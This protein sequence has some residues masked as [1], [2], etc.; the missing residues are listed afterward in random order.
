MRESEALE[1]V[2][3]VSLHSSVRVH[4]HASSTARPEHAFHI[5]SH[6]PGNR[7]IFVIL[8]TLGMLEAPVELVC[9][10]GVTDDNTGSSAECIRWPAGSAWGVG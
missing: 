8:W 5:P 1:S 10:N 3:Q 7:R 4:A 6:R 2:K 9:V